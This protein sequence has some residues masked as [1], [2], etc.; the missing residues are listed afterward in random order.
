M[1]ALN[2]NETKA[3][4]DNNIARGWEPLPVQGA[5]NRAFYKNDD[6]TIKLMSYET[7]VFEYVIAT[8]ELIRRWAG[9]SAT[10]LKHVQMFMCWLHNEPYRR[11]TTFGKANWD[12]MDVQ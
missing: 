2:W 4:R 3:M 9:Y 6:V 8:G 11:N 12:A 1:Y 5:N 10:T 7:V